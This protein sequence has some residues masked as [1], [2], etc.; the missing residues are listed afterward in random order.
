[1][2]RKNRKKKQ[3]FRSMR[4]FEKEFFPKSFDKKVT[5]KPRDAQALG[6][7]LAKESFEKIGSI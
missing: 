4:E 2:N 3:V 5:R 7:S 6:I 1:M